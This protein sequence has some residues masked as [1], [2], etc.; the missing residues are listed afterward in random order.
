M[1]CCVPAGTTVNVIS[2]PGPAP[3]LKAAAVVNWP[4]RSEDISPEP[5]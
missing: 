4:L 2:A 5:E 3:I 1:R